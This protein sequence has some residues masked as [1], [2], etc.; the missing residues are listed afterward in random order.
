MGSQATDGFFTIFLILYLALIVVMLAS[1]WKLFAKAGKPG[2]ASIVPIYNIIVL[3]EIVGRPLWW[4]ILL[5]IPCVNIVVGIMVTLD[6][7]KSYGKSVGFA[8]GLLL[9]PFIFLPMMA[10]SD[11]TDYEGPAAGEGSYTPQGR[12][13]TA[14]RQQ[15]TA[16]PPTEGINF[17]DD[18]DL[19]DLDSIIDKEQDDTGA[20]AADAGQPDQDKPK[21]PKRKKGGGPSPGAHK[22]GKPPPGM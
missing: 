2:W 17:D 19:P 4:I 10:F 21:P 7:A 15:Q 12:G 18:D 14:S 6:F 1:Y 22:K 5:L 16:I 20:G 9:L 13:Y 3:L 8:I 11:E